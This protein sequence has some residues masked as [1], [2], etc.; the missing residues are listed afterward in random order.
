[1]SDT[2]KQ[3]PL[4]VNSLNSLLNIEGLRINAKVVSWAGT[5]QSFG[6]YSFGRLVQETVLRVITHA[7]H[8]GYYG[9]PDGIPYN[10][11]YNNLISIGGGTRAIPITSITSGVVSGTEQFYFD[12]VYN[13]TFALTPGSY[14]RIN[15]ATPGGYIG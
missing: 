14:V 15:G 11:V 9:N 12:V 8:E 2:G 5:S 7:I 13:Q 3:S 10:S 4:G 1:M 6:S